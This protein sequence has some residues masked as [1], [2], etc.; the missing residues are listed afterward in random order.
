MKKVA[1]RSVEWKVSHIEY[2]DNL[3]FKFI[4]L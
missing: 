2:I 4:L 1:E 3:K